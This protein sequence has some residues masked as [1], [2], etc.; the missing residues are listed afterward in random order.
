[1]RKVFILCFALCIVFGLQQLAFGQLS[2]GA[3][4]FEG[5]LKAYQEGRYGEAE[6]LFR[7]V[8]V[9]VDKAAK[10]GNPLAPGLMSDTLNALALS[11]QGQG[12]FAEAEEILLKVIQLLEKE[13]IESDADFSQTSKVLNNLG[14]IYT[15]EHKFKEAEETHRKAIRLREEHDPPPRRNLAISLLN[16]GKVYY[17]QGK[18]LE[19]EP[20]FRQARTILFAI[21]ESD[22][23]DEDIDTL[24]MISN[25]LA[26]TAVERGQF[27]EAEYRYKE[28]IRL[29]EARK[30]PNHP[31]LVQYLNNYAKLLR[32]TKRPAEAK[33][34][35]A[36]ALRIS[37]QN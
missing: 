1:M 7:L 10:E 28:V 33:R 21:S 35:E 18:F 2:V 13:R 30:G 22:A 36:R 9:E 17:D 15:E 19:A 8:V 11:L 31:D 6:R 4:L 24:L 26:L 27:R 14:L 29:T 16:L 20:F 23:T 32:L 25:N 37:K 3:T 34:V 5:G 12:K